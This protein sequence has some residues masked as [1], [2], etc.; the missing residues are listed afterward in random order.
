[1]NRREF[2]QY[3]LTGIVL[4]GVLPSWEASAETVYYNNI[5]GGKIKDAKKPAH[6]VFDEVKTASSIIVPEDTRNPSYHS[7][8]SKRNAS[9]YGAISTVASRGGHDV[10]VERGDPVIK[11]YVNINEAVKKQIKESEK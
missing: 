9:V 6:V 4:A 7:Q 2:L 3:G 1:M 11:D 5:P 8:L 10:V